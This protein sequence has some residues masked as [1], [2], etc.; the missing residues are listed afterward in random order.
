VSDSSQLPITASTPS[1]AKRRARALIGWLSEQ[2]G[3]LWAAGRDQQAA[4]SQPEHLEACK[5]A[6]QHVAART[7][8]IDQSNLF[9]QVPAELQPHIHALNADPES[10]QV[11]ATSGEIR[12]VDLRRVCAAQPHVLVE[13][14][15]RRI[16]GIAAGDFLALAAVTLPLPKRE[17]FPVTFDPHKNTWLLASPNPNLRVIG[18]FSTSVGPGFA[19]FGFAVGQQQSYMQVAGVNGRYFLRDGYHRAYGLVSAGITHAP[20]LVKDFHTLE[21]AQL[22]PGL[23]PQ[24]AYLGDRPPLLVDY[25]DDAVSVDTNI[26]STTK[27]IV[28]QALEVSSIA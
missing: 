22:P 2:E 25:L 8:G 23:L 28:I 4:T 6:R 9:Q 17:Q 16:K 26:P 14:A 13:D 24:S 10:A 1:Y 15:T 21:E 7:P 12:I 3:A 11:L 27:M 20:A 5:R 19:G 18:N